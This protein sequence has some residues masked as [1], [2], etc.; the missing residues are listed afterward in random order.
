MFVSTLV[1]AIRVALTPLLHVPMPRVPDE[2]SYLLMADTFA[3]GRLANPTHPMWVHFETLFVNQRPTYSS[4]YPAMQGIFL[5]LGERLG[6]PWVG[7]LLSVAILCGAICWMLQGWLPHRWALL[8][9]LLAVIQFGTF[10]YWINSYWGGAPAGLGGALVFGACGR[11]RKRP[12]ARNSV[13][14]GLGAAILANSRPYESLILA[15][16]V[17]V[18]L[19]S[20]ARKLPGSVVLRQIAIPLALVL[21]IAMAATGYYFWRVTGRPWTSP[22]VP[23]MKEYAAS[24]IFIWENVP[25]PPVYRHAVLRDAHLSFRN[26]FQAYGSY[27]ESHGRHSSRLAAR[28][29][30]I[31]APCCSCRS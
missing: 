7:V 19:A 1:L 21:A 29:V 9:G 14:L 31:W 15:I 10:S 30:S 8:G 28:S 25:A 18:L 12:S 13:I 16:P 24:P 23:Y 27:S 5:A 20:V 11:L 17:L 6:N 3:S 2:F 4:V 26:D 22:Y